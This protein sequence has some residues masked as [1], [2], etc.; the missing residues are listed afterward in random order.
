MLDTELSI[1]EINLSIVTYVGGWR[2]CVIVPN[3]SW[4]MLNYEADLLAM[5]LKGYLYEF[6]IKR[7]WQDFLKDF[8]KSRCAH[9]SDLVSRFYYVLPEKIKDR[10]LNYLRM[11]F[12]EQH[13]AVLIYTEGRY[14]YLAGGQPKR[15]GARPLSMSN[16]FALARLGTMRYWNLL[17]TWQ[18]YHADKKPIPDQPTMDMED[19]FDE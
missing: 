5:S 16:Q 9:N 18:C 14:L 3:V 8:T 15:R 12:G 17:E 19:G 13:P 11:K 10:A 2:K 7:S 4:G 6:E 1:S